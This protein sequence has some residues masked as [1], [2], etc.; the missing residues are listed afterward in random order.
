M[1]RLLF[2]LVAVVTRHATTAWV[3]PP[4]IRTASSFASPTSFFVPRIP[5]PARP[6][7]R[8]LASTTEDGVVE[9]EDI[10]T[11]EQRDFVRG[12]LNKHHT[13]FLLALV[14]AFSEIGTEMAQANVW[15]GG[16]YTVPSAAL[17]DVTATHVTLEATIQRRGPPDKAETRRVTLSLDAVPERRRACDM[18]SPMIAAAADNANP[19]RPATSIDRLVR[20]LCRWAWMVR[21]PAV[22]GQLLQLAWQLGG[23]GIGKLPDNMYVFGM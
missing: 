17:V 1:L 13:P 20:S 19:L 7:R 10:L 14:T 21:Q 12:Y 18:D 8:V 5:R 11:E 4:T 3:P 2:L 15:S 6:K 16:S 22:T 23:A 9:V